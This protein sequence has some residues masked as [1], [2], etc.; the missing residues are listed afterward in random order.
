[1]VVPS[2]F[3]NSLILPATK[4]NLDNVRMA[5]FHGSKISEPQRINWNHNF[6]RM[7]DLAEEY[8]K[9]WVVRVH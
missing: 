1:M 6:K 2:S 9:T 3:N 7:I 4:G 8:T 5:I